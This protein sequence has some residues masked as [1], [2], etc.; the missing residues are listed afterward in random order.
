VDTKEVLSMSNQIVRPA[1]VI[2]HMTRDERTVV[3]RLVETR[4]VGSEPQATFIVAFLMARGFHPDTIAQ[5]ERIAMWSGPELA[6]VDLSDPLFEM[7]SPETLLTVEDFSPL[8]DDIHALD[9]T[10]A[11]HL[12]CTALA[13]RFHWMVIHA[14]HDR[15]LRLA[16]RQRTR[17]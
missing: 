6:D 16:W 4:R 8:P 17:R 13:E 7:F 9:E 15:A 3:D 12:A 1:A 14:A 5:A 2:R 10:I 11:Q